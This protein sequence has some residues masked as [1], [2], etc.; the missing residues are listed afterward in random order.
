MEELLEWC[1]FILMPSEEYRE[2]QVNNAK[3]KL[4]QVKFTIAREKNTVDQEI[5]RKLR[6]L[7]IMAK[8]VDVD[9]NDVIDKVREIKPLRK[10]QKLFANSL[11]KLGNLETNLNQVQQ[12]AQ[13]VSCM[14]NVAHVVR[15]TNKEM[16]SRATKTVLDKYEEDFDTL[17][18]A[19]GDIDLA[20]DQTEVVDDDLDNEEALLIQ[21]FKDEHLRNTVQEIYPSVPTH[22]PGTKPSSSRASSSSSS[23]LSRTS[24]AARHKREEKFQK[25]GSDDDQDQF[26]GSNSNGPERKVRHGTRVVHESHATP[27]GPLHNPLFIAPVGSRSFVVPPSDSSSSF[28]SYS[29]SSSSFFSSSSL[30]ASNSQSRAT[31]IPSLSKKSK[32]PRVIAHNQFCL[33]DRPPYFDE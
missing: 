15:L 18:T 10:R 23:S 30:M 1:L 24:T 32:T 12:S 27:L 19:Q 11:L 31:A 26:N 33:N 21:H 29:S 4:V 25:E 13:I 3:F 16:L 7:N 14:K 9:M 6:R 5:K 28:S 2:Y 22:L 17:L 20:I 8:D